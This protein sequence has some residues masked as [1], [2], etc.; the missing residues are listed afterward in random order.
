MRPKQTQ[1]NRVFQMYDTELE[2]AGGPFII[3]V[4][5]YTARRLSKNNPTKTLQYTL[6]KNKQKLTF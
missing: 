5:L 2:G 1:R 3:R 6:Y 4:F